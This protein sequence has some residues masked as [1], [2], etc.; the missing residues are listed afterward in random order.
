[1][2]KIRFNAIFVFCLHLLILGTNSVAMAADEQPGMTKEA[3]A[4]LSSILSKAFPGMERIGQIRTGQLGHRE[5]VVIDVLVDKIR[6]YKFIA[7]G[8]PQVTDLSLSVS[9]DGKEVASD[10]T[11]GEQPT[12]QWCSSGPAKASVKITMYGGIGSYALLVYGEKPP[13]TASVDKVG[14]SGTDFIA[15]RIRQLHSQFGKG[16]AAVSKLLK[17]NLP[18]GGEKI[19][20]VQLNGGHC[21]SIIGTGSPSVRNLD[22][23]LA[24]STGRELNK[25]KQRN[26]MPTLDT[27]PCLRSSDR[28]LVK[29]RMFSGSGQ[30]GVQVFSD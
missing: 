17:G 10:R 14:G 11:S 27:N 15:N 2:K 9:V 25:D 22:I 4:K 29:I 20:K 18:T 21:Y 12:A 30:F 8:G 28:Y 1:M 26:N 13:Q 19:F 5:S 23:V 6:C 16:R 24:D 3:K 7:A